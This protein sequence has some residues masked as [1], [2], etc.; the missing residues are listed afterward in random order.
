MPVNQSLGPGFVAMP[1]RITRIRRT[2]R[3]AGPHRHLDP[4]SL[5]RCASGSA[6]TRTCRSRRSSS[7]GSTS[8]SSASTASG[9]ATTSSSRAGPTGRT[10]RAGRCW[11]ALAARTERIRVGVLVSSN[12]FRH[13]AL[14]AKE[15]VTLDHISNGR[16]E[17]GLGAGWFV[18]GARAVRHRVPAA[19]RARRAVP[20]GGRDRRQPAAQRD[21]DLRGPVLPA[22]TSAYVRPAPVQQPRPPLTLG[23]HRPRML[24]ICAEYA[25]S[26]NSFGTRRRDPRAER[27]PRR[28]LRRDRARPREI[29]RSFYGWASNMTEQGLPDPWKT[30]GGVRGRDR[31]LRRSRHQRVRHGSASA[32]AVRR[33]RAGCERCSA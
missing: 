30:H 8:S 27:D 5:A 1:F 19:R 4:V 6:P 2:L 17:L 25:D 28:A 26:W 22:R 33:A 3:C 29:T 7:A 13:P 10:S 21:D 24:R 9:T 15:A 23:A 16:L 32:G 14:L 12:T 20:R 18:A 11:P 31:P